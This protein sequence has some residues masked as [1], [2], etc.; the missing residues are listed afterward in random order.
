MKILPN[1]KHMSTQDKINLAQ[2]LVIIPVV[3]ISIPTCFTRKSHF[4][5]DYYPDPKTLL[6]TVVPF[7]ICCLF[8]KFFVNTLFYKLG[9]KFLVHK[10]QWTPE[11]RD[12]RVKRFA[13]CLFKAIY[14]FYSASFGFVLFKHEDWMPKILYG[15][16]KQEYKYLWES[17][18]YQEYNPCIVFYYIFGLGYHLHSLVFHMMSEKKG[19]YMENLLHHLATVFLMVFSFC[20][21]CTRIGVLVLIVHDLVD[22]V[23]YIGKV[24]HD[25]KNQV[26]VYIIFST[27]VIIYFKYRVYYF[28]RYIIWEGALLGNQYLPFEVPGLFTNY[29]MMIGLLWVL[30]GLHLYWF[31]LI[32]M[33]IVDMIKANGSII[34]PHTVNKKDDDKKEEKEDGKEE[35]KEKKE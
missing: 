17:Y 7:A 5:D 24:C 25:M 2:I 31:Y 29:Y 20:N 8:R 11:Y 32:I 22:F 16:G 35:E 9:D 28:P 34:D 30:W 4:P 33:M 12:F 1:F 13:L 18:P 14:F 21:Q 27:L 19:D 3:L 26:P 15:T 23:L 6:W 10:P